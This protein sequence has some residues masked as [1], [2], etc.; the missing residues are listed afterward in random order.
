M[1]DLHQQGILQYS[2][3]ACISWLAAVLLFLA[4]AVNSIQKVV[5]VMQSVSILHLIPPLLTDS[6]LLT[7][8]A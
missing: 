4:V 8:Q 1:K 5:G 6:Y 7:Y 2:C 3:S